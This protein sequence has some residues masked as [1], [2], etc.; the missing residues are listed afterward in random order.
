MSDKILI[1]DQ[2]SP[3]HNDK[4]SY[5]LCSFT[6]DVTFISFLF[7][8]TAGYCRW[9]Q[10]SSLCLEISGAEMLCACAPMSYGSNRGIGCRSRHESSERWYA[11]ACALLLV[12]RVLAINK[13]I[14]WLHKVYHRCYAAT[15]PQATTKW[16]A[17]SLAFPLPPD[18]MCYRSH[19][20]TLLCP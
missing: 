16:V 1:W 6:L 3:F 9:N 19:N 7:L 15:C 10:S 8:V 12:R 20:H 17:V 4:I 11:F 13:L 18:V 14:L 2:S 5:Y